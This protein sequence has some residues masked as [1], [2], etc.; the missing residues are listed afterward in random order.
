MKS[1]DILVE[2]SILNPTNRTRLVYPILYCYRH[3]LELAM[4]WVIAMFG[5][6]ADI[7]SSDHLDHDLWTLWA[8]CKKIIFAVCS[9]DDESN[10][11]L[12]AVQQI[13]K[14]FHD[15]DRIAMAFRYSDD[16]NGI[17]FKLPDYPIDLSNIRS[18][19]Q[20]VGRFFFGVE[21]QLEDII[22]SGDFD[23]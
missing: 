2:D 19:M 4:K 22:A 12:Q 3:G 9:D 13:V 7:C 5:Q 14:D 6:Y 10:E 17:G 16:K 1:G 23:I 11:A 21:G 8:A 15:W 18:V 20:A